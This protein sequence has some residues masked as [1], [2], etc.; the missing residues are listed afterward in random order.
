MNSFSVIFEFRP[1]ESVEFRQIL[2]KCAEFVN[3]ARYCCFA[4]H[5]WLRAQAPRFA[6]DFFQ[7]APSRG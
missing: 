5:L 1:A 6:F 3:P 7:I 4:F 2:A